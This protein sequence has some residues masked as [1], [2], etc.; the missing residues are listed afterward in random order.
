MYIDW[1]VEANRPAAPCTVECYVF[2]DE[3]LTVE[4]MVGEQKTQEIGRN[5]WLYI[6]GVS[7]GEKIT[8]T[9][10]NN[11]FFTGEIPVD[12]SWYFKSNRET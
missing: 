11:I 6:N 8:L 4:L 1:S 7:E 3:E 2:Y 12:G 9:I 10:D 5:L